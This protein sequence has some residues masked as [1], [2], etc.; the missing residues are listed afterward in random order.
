MVERMGNT[1]MQPSQGNPGDGDLARDLDPREMAALERPDL[2]ELPPELSARRVRKGRGATL[3][4]A[5]R[6][7]R[8]VASPFDDGWQ[9]MEAELADLPPLP[10]TLIRDASRTVI[11]WNQSPDIGFDRAV[12]P[13]RG[14]EHG[15]VYC[16]ARP[17]HA[18]LGY[19]PGLDFE[20]KLLFKPDVAE[21]LGKELRKPGYIARPLALGSNTDPYQ[22]EER[23]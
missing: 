14:C 9:T 22:P 16:Y 20:T 12:N 23:T 18:Y 7:D 13:Y 17:T 15:C 8:Q 5:N 21:L 2:P 19:S 3:N 10:T 11:S 4:P 6:Y 1:T